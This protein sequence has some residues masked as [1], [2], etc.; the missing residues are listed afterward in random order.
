M[1]EEFGLLIALAIAAG[2]GLG[3]MLDRYAQWLAKD[4]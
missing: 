3:I 1:T 4:L 2:V